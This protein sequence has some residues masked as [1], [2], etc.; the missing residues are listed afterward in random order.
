MAM[1]GLGTITEKDFSIDRFIDILR[2]FYC[3]EP[4]E[5]ERVLNLPDNFFSDG[6][7]KCKQNSIDYFMKEIEVAGISGKYL[8][9]KDDFM[10]DSKRSAYPDDPLAV[11]IV[12]HLLSLLCVSGREDKEMRIKTNLKSRSSMVADKKNGE[13]AVDQ[14]LVVLLVEALRDSTSRERLINFIRAESSNVSSRK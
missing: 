6:L 1:S 12:A 14:E 11:R 13:P 5:L 3:Q 4:E 10:F 2:H 9:G 8:I 7:F